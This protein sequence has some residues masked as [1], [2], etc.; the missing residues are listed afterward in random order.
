MPE[1]KR[2][3]G[4]ILLFFFLFVTGMIL[5][6]PFP[7]WFFP[8][9]GKFLSPFSLKIL[10]GIWQK[11]NLSLSSDSLG[12]KLTGLTWFLF[13]AFLAGLMLL[14]KKVAYKLTALINRYF[15]SFV[16]FYLSM[17][18]FRYGWDKVFKHQFYL[19]E[20]NILFTPLGNLDRDILYWS[21][22]GSSYSFTVFGGI[23]EVIPAVLLLFR[24][25][26]I[27]GAWIAFMVMIQVVMINFGFDITVKCFSLFLLMLSFY[28]ILPSISPVFDFF[29]SGKAITLPL[30]DRL[31]LQTRFWGG[32]VFLKVLFIALI[33]TETLYPFVK[34]RNF[35]D[36][37]FPRPPYHGA[38]EVL[39][40]VNN[41][42]TLPHENLN[43][44]KRCFFHRQ[45]YFIVQFSDDTMKDYPCDFDTISGKLVLYDSE[46]Q[47]TGKFKIIKE[48]A[49]HSM[50]LNGLLGKDSLSVSV[51]KVKN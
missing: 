3:S 34:T 17:Q 30:P 6:I 33:L 23:M 27:L 22:M 49:Y 8:D 7:Y 21:T 10:E 29:T 51:R 35:N 4:F 32:Y 1:G 36:D 25:T 50:K 19:P 38:F 41:G 24:K 11:T 12:M 48:N 44:W 13:S 5:I 45:G 26:R 16:S 20:P 37:Q 15:P 31:P 46:Y 18:L 40:F 43:R 2:F 42:D 39:S 47:E 28:L 14:F 9:I